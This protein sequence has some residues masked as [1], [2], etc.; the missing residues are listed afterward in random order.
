[1]KFN[2]AIVDGRWLGDGEDEGGDESILNAPSMPIQ[3]IMEYA[4]L[5]D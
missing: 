5:E 3:A 1:M 4:T 2:E